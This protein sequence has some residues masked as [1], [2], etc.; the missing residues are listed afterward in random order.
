MNMKDANMIYSYYIKNVL[1]PII[2][3]LFSG[4]QIE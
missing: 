2:T 3:L 1:N 4:L